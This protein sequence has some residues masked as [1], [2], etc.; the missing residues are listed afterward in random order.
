MIS[1]SGLLFIE[2][3]N[4]ASV[5]PVI[6]DL[7]RRMTAAY[8]AARPGYPKFC[9]VHTCV[10]GAMS[11]GHNFAVAVEA[12][13]HVTAGL[14]A[15]LDVVDGVARHEAEGLRRL[16]EAGDVVLALAQLAHHGPGARAALE[17]QGQREVQFVAAVGEAHDAAARQRGRHVEA[18]LA[19]AHRPVGLRCDRGALLPTDGEPATQRGRCVVSRST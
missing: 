4:A 17:A 16:P 11:E 6:D 10:C 14:E 7:T 5:V 1:K 8:R 15:H 12:H 2:P 18:V 19:Q 9:G 3:Q 13:Q